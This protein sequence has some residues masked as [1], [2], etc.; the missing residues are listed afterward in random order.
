MDEVGTLLRHDLPDVA[1][2]GVFLATGLATLILYRLRERGRDRAWLWFSLFAILFG[3]RLLSNTGALR[4]AVPV[5][6][7]FWQYLDAE[8]T[9][10]I[11]LPVMLLLWEIFPNWR[12]VLRWLLW[13]MAVFGAV[14][15]ASDIMQREP[16]TLHRINSVVVLILLAAVFVALFRQHGRTR[17]VQTL[18]AGMLIASASIVINNFFSIA[19]WNNFYNPEP[20]GLL[21][22]LISLGR[23]L[24]RRAFQN[25]ER[26]VE[27]DK[28]LE[29][30][31]R[32][33]T[34]ILPAQTPGEPHWDVAAHYQPMTSVA[35][36]FYD[37]LIVDEQRAG[38][39]VAD[40]SGHG[41]PAALIASMVKVA[42][43]A[44]LPHADRPE[45]VLSGMNRTLCGNLKGQYVTAAYLYADLAA[46]KMR[47]AAAGHPALLWQHADGSVEEVIENGLMLGLFPGAAY[48]AR[49][50]DLE[51]GDRFLLYTDGVLEAAN[52]AGDFFGV[53]RV[54]AV[55]GE[56][57]WQTSREIATTLLDRVVRWS[58]AAQD[59]V[60]LIAV[61]WRQAHTKST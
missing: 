55:L 56:T 24:G 1:F 33:Q 21:A 48:T 35:G 16:F 9:Y 58:P 49:A 37:F 5:P 46:Q 60:T 59:D 3:V 22:L 34:S 31:R 4:I 29:I 36:D 2:S 50:A 39:L 6:S 14:G 61:G 40:V 51:P 25:E 57:R 44:Q 41:V 7:H 15:I 13:A 23:V 20:L 18:R 26:L 30:A 38:I 43:A 27:L 32:I 12:V 19:G 8:I 17:D 42:I 52:E 54:K 10:V 28:E 11:E 45:A 47:Y 53:E